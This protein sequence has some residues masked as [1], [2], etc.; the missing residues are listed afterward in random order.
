MVVIESNVP[1]TIKETKKER[2]FNMVP[3]LEAIPIIATIPQKPG[4]PVVCTISVKST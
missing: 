4:T 3:G 1:L 2:V